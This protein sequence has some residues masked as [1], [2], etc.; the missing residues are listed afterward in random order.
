MKDRSDENGDSKRIV[1]GKNQS[2]EGIKRNLIIEDGQKGSDDPGKFA[3]AANSELAEQ[4]KKLLI[5]SIIGNAPVILWAVEF[6]GIPLFCEGKGLEAIGEEPGEIGVPPVFDAQQSVETI[7]QR[8]QRSL[9]GETICTTEKKHTKD[10]DVA[11]VNWQVPLRGLDGEIIGVG[12][13]AIDITERKKIEDKLRAECRT[14]KQLLESQERDRQLTA[15]EIHDGLAQNAIGAHMQLETLLQTDCGLNDRARAM[16]DKCQKL[17]EKTV[18]EAR[19]LISGLRP[20][21]LDKFGVVAA[22]RHM[23]E[24]AAGGGIEVTFEAEVSAHRFTPLLEGAV[25]RIAQEAINNAIRHSKSDR[26]QVRL[27]ETNEQIELEV[28]DCGIGFDPSSIEET[29]FG[30]QGMRERARLLCGQLEIDSSPGKGT[31]VFVKM[32]IPTINVEKALLSDRS[33]A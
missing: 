33:N 14:L 32:P 22:I 25:F 1:R 18:I 13:L 31:R 26:I 21:I 10:K 29:R 7:E 6:R 24:N 15:F 17:V 2:N 28:V 16:I 11:F 30:I 19:H 12:G 9:N 23:V 4:V 5:N 20:P 8:L 3:T 27:R